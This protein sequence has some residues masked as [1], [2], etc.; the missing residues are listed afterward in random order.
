[1]LVAGRFLVLVDNQK[2]TTTKISSFI[3]GAE[4]FAGSQWLSWCI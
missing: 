2:T 1:M 4:I 3:D